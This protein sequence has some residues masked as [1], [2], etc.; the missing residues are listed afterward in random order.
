VSTLFIPLYVLGF[1]LLVLG[2]LVALGRFRGGRYLRPIMQKLTKAPLLG[3]GLKKM[4]QA[5][6]ERQNPELAS[7]VKK[8]ERMGAQT[9]PRRAQQALAQLSKAEREAFLEAAGEELQ[10]QGPQ[11]VNRAQR[12]QMQRGR[13]GQVQR[14]RGRGRKRR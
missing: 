3:R 6:L 9:D 12:R 1:L 10:Q 13:Q 14:Q 11:A 5:A 8:L 7:A 2:V 4:S